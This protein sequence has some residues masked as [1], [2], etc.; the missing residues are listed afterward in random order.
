MDDSDVSAF[1]RFH[2][3]GYQEGLA[4]GSHAGMAEGRRYGALH[5]ARAG[6]EVNGETLQ[7][8]DLPVPGK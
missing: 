5:G 8:R 3:E 2:R 1:P 7:R 6:S 4:E